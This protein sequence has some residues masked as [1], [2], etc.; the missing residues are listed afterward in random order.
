M[1][2]KYYLVFSFEDYEERKD[3]S[4]LKK[5]LSTSAFTFKA[6]RR[7]KNGKSI[8]NQRHI[9]TLLALFPLQKRT[10]KFC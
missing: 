1:P 6:I 7:T 9:Y 5:W 2:F 4:I 8:L 10:L 3:V